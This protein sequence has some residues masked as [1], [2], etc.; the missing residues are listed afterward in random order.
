VSHQNDAVSDHD[1]D[2][3]GEDESPFRSRPPIPT[4]E[5]LELLATA[6]IEVLGQ[7]PYSSNATFLVDLRVGD[8]VPAQAIYKPERGERPLWDFPGSLYRREVGAFLLSEQLGWGHVPPTIEVDG[9]AGIGS[10]Q[11]FIPALFDEHYFTL[12]DDERWFEAFKEICAFDF[13]ANNTDRKAGH[14]LLGADDELWAIDNGLSFHQEFKLRTVIWDFAG[15][16]LTQNVIEGLTKFLDEGISAALAERLTPF[17]RDACIAR[18]RALL[19]SG[20]YPSDPT[21]RRYPWPMV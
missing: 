17:E 8:T 10:I 1:E 3:H 11:L 15:E 14:V 2:D 4:N 19:Y 16:D 12:L 21:G 9:P 18:A 7:M 13:V 5:A 20:E 6:E